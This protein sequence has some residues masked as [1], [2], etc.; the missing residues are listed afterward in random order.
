MLVETKRDK[1]IGLIQEAV[2]G[3][4]RYWAGLIANHLIE[5]GIEFPVHCENCTFIIDRTDNTH[6]CYVHL[7][8]DTQHGFYCCLGE[9]QHEQVRDKT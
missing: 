6:G 8:E 4:A 2:P 3:V 7:G 9:M 5:N 1:L